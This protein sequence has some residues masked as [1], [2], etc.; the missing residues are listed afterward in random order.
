ML[1]P[2]P[3][4]G[5]EFLPPSTS[6]GGQ[7]AHG[8]GGRD[9]PPHGGEAPDPSYVPRCRHVSLGAGGDRLDPAQ[10]QPYRWEAKGH[11]A[12]GTCAVILAWWCQFRILQSSVS[13]ASPVHRASYF[14]S[15]CHTCVNPLHEFFCDAPTADNCSSCDIVPC[16][17]AKTSA[18][19]RSEMRDVRS[20][21]SP[22]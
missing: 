18:T 16:A 17:Q 19:T 15:P 5:R 4:H 20:P 10:A 9:D 12:R 3:R 13:T 11:R 14:V 8:E 2:G 6:D 22:G 21:W 1:F 7:G